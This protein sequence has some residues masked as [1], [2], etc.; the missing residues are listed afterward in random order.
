[1]LPTTRYSAVPLPV[2]SLSAQCQI[3]TPLVAQ[4]PNDEPASKLLKSISAFVENKPL[5]KQGRAKQTT[6]VPKMKA[7]R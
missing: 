6:A 2:S 7:T 4:D 1:M 5:P 3:H